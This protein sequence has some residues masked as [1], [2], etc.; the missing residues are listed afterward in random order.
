MRRSPN[1]RTDRGPRLTV[2]VFGAM[3]LVVLAGAGTL[4]LVSLLVAPAVFHQHLHQ[5]GVTQSSDVE[6]HVEEG[7]ATATLVSTGLG[8]LAASAVA[9]AMALLVARRISRPVTVA[10]RT[11]TQLAG[12]DYS[13]RVTSP[14]MGPE[15]ADLADSVN[16]LAE[17][18]E[19]SERIRIRLMSDLAH[20]LRTP[21]ASIDATV[22]AIADNVLPADA[23]TLAT[24]T[25][26]SQRLGRLIDDLAAVSRAEEGA[27]RLNVRPIDLAAVTR[28]AAAAAAARFAAAGVALHGPGTAPVA[29]VGD[30]DRIGEVVGQLLDNALHH[31]NPGDVVSIQVTQRAESAELTVSDNGGGFE[32]T[33]DELIFQRFYRADPA[34]VDGSGSG[35]GLT[36]ARTLIEAHHGTLRAS[37]PGPGRGATFTLLL[38]SAKASS[39]N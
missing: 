26:S 36:I 24:L 32:P 29:V 5:A 28:D 15:L 37:S 8:V 7:F 10:S 39:T 31:T 16:A 27:F 9:A 18:L 25:R 11:A 19:S 35:I 21:L 38:P 1:A 3:G 34:R 2:R 14:S 33:D 23:Q 13:A 6:R 30:P 12:G 22:E 4:I 20:E 17:R